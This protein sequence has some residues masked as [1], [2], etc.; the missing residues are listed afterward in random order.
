VILVVIVA[1]VVVRPPKTLPKQGVLTIELGLL[2][3]ELFMPHRIYKTLK[4]SHE[5]SFQRDLESQYPSKQ[6][7]SIVAVFDGYGG[8]LRECFGYS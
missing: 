1:V 6:A 4:K 2:G 3:L 7:F 5:Y 8:S